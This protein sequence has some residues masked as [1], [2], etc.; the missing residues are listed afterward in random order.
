MR[1]RSILLVLFASLILGAGS[2]LIGCATTGTERATKTTRSMQ[3]VENEYYQVTSQVDATNASL[4]E[5]ISPNQTD[6]KK[7]F[8]KYK[9]EVDTME[10]LGKQLDQ[11]SADM[12]ARGQNYFSEWEKQEATYSNPQIRQLSDERRIQLRDVF[13]RIP[14]A[15]SGVRQSLHSYLADIKDI[16]K[17]LSND[18]TP[19]GVE[20]IEPVAQK[21]IQDGDELKI[22]V[23][24]V[25]A[26]I[27][28]ARTAMSQGGTGTGSAAGG[29]Q[30]G[31][32]QPAEQPAAEEP[33]QPAEQPAAEQSGQPKEPPE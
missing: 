32:E 28:R 2:G 4:Q 31:D 11:D 12:K 25:L 24:P 26:A 20:A 27:Q 5:V 15:S 29:E 14:E 17:Y 6:L 10:R 23:K 22:S 9:T 3:T 1:Q 21:A 18:L 19:Q 30:S 16:R 7:A 8:E 33:G 13:A